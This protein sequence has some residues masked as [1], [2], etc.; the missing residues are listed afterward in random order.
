MPIPRG[1]SRGGAIE[2]FE[3]VSEF[4]DENDAQSLHDAIQEAARAAA[5]KLQPGETADF[6]ISRLQI[7]V[8]NPNVKAYRV[9]ITR[10][11]G[12]P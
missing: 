10:T 11:D 4:R 2:A 7:V 9:E 1:A 8:G 12:T 3:G 5:Q 6:D